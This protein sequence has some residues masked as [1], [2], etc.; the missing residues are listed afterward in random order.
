MFMLDKVDK[1]FIFSTNLKRYLNEPWTWSESLDD[2]GEENP[3]IKKLSFRIIPLVRVSLKSQILLIVWLV[4][5]CI[6]DIVKLDIVLDCLPYK[7]YASQSNRRLLDT[8]S[9]VFRFKFCCIQVLI[10]IIRM[11]FGFCSNMFDFKIF[12]FWFVK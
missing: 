12:K 5:I 4:N 10:K 6:F 1:H 9:H 3:Y 8:N 2:D 11:L 7:A